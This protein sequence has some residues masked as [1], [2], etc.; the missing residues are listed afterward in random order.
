MTTTQPP[1]LEEY[2]RRRN[3]RRTTEPR[4]GRGRRGARPI[5]VV[6]KHD[7]SRLLIALLVAASGAL[8]LLRSRVG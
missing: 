2:R 7:A 8:F 3:F 1:V 6:Q 4:G 5:F